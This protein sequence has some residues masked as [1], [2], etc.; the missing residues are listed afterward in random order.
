MR[1]DHD[2]LTKYFEDAANEMQAKAEEQK[3]LLGHYEDK[4][5][6]Y[7]REVRDLISPPPRNQNGIVAS[8]EN[9]N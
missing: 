6:L 5:S 8:S 1:S 7:D 9:T 2:A 4:S 3:K